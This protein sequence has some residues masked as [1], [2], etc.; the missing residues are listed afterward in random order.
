[1]PKFNIPVYWSMVATME[2]EAA[3][4]EEAIKLAEDAP[5]PTNDGE[6]LDGSFEINH[7]II[8][9]VNENLCLYCGT[10]CHTDGGQG[11]DEFN[12]DGFNK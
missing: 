4:I 11:C 2:V 12:A 5:L 7:D 9:A 10:F 1:M 3:T 8:P 6:Y